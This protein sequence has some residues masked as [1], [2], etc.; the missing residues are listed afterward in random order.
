[1]VLKWSIMTLVFPVLI[2]QR[3]VCW[4]SFLIGLPQ[5]LCSHV[6]CWLVSG[7]EGRVAA[8]LLPLPRP[9][10]VVV[11]VSNMH[12]PFNVRDDSM[13][14]G[15]SSLEKA[16][17]LHNSSLKNVKFP[18][19]ACF[20]SGVF[21]FFSGQEGGSTVA[22]HTVAYKPRL[23]SPVRWGGWK[24]P[25]QEQVSPHF[26]LSLL[27]CDVFLSSY[28]V[29]IVSLS[30]CGWHRITVLLFLCPY[31]HMF[32]IHAKREL[33]V[34]CFCRWYIF[35][36]RIKDFVNLLELFSVL[37]L[38]NFAGQHSFPQGFG[39]DTSDEGTIEVWRLMYRQLDMKGRLRAVLR[40]GGAS[41]T[42]TFKF[43]LKGSLAL[44]LKL[45]LCC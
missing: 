20:W 22:Q 9:Q 21:W 13:T 6:I 3:A 43:K 29:Q 10:A 36:C 45:R 18:P 42:L 31:M 27:L 15:F 11:G 38:H 26:L 19:Q 41:W 35:G 12:Q 16:R 23:T 40:E 30:H 33:P 25:E 39:R 28:Q 37:R 2:R 34:S 32:H 14:H 4:E 44:F 7:S 5:S 1:M 24:R 8:Q 17:I